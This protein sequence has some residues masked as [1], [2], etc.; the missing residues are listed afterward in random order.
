MTKHMRPAPHFTVQCANELR[1]GD[2]TCPLN[3]FPYAPI[4]TDDVSPKRLDQ[5][6]AFDL[7][8]VGTEKVQP[9]ID[10]RDLC[11]LWRQTKT[12][13]ARKVEQALAEPYVSVSAHTAPIIQPP[14]PGPSAN[15]RIVRIASGPMRPCVTRALRTNQNEVADDCISMVFK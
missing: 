2:R 6:F 3:E 7:A 11:L 10:V 13:S 5:E 9:C 8:Y 12:R 14:A 15:A 4:E 1:C